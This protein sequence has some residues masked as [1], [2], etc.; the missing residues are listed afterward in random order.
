M[1]KRKKAILTPEAQ[2]LLDE[3]P[4]QSRSM[5]TRFMVA[6]PEPTLPLATRIRVSLRREIDELLYQWGRGGGKATMQGFIDEA[7]Q[8]LLDH[9][10][11]NRSGGNASKRL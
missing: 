2:A 3:Q 4:V 8:R 11:P 1:T 7:C 6:A 5:P 10:R 9:Y